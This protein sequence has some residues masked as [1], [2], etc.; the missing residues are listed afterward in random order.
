MS[1][2]TR[3][4]VITHLATGQQTVVAASEMRCTTAA[5]ISRLAGHY[6]PADAQVNTVPTHKEYALPFDELP[7]IIRRP[8]A[9]AERTEAA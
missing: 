9:V 6:A 2:R 7:L 5:S 3:Q 4:Y 8:D 1:N